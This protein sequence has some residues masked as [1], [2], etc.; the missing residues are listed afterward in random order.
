MPSDSVVRN[1]SSSSSR[2]SISWPSS[3]ITRTFRQSACIS[4]M[5]TLKLSGMPGSGMFSPLTIASYTFTRPSTSSDLMVRISCSAYAAPYASSAHTSI[6]PN[7][8]PPN[9][10]LPPSGC[11]VIIEYGPV[12]RAWILS[13]TRC[14][15]FRMYM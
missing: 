5:S 9:C 14:D 13:S 8:W 15:S 6:S 2:I 11:C 7:R 1:A 10:A 12:D 4:L 3:F